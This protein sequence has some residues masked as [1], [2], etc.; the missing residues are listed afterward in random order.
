MISD[1]I[2]T[3]YEVLHSMKISKAKN[4]G[5]MAIKLDMSKA[6]DR[7][8]WNFIRA[9][10]EKLGFNAT[11]VSWI[12]QCITSASYAVLINGEAK[13]FIRP[14]R[15]IR[16]GDPLSPYLFI[17]CAEVLSCLL[18]KAEERDEFHG[19]K[20][21]RGAPSVNHLFFADDSLI[22]CGANVR[23][24]QNILHVIEIYENASGQRINRDK[25]NLFFN[26]NIGETIQATIKGFWGAPVTLSQEKYLGLH[27]IVGR[28]KK[29]AFVNLK[30]RVLKRIQG[31]R[32]KILSTGGKEIL[33]KAVAQ[34]IPSYTMSC[35]QLPKGLCNDLGAL[36]SKFW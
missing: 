14:T 8:E 6:Y 25:T 3:A 12:M 32:D 23:E 29:R 30:D 34:A 24:C 10:M 17:L 13:G 9:V 2:L 5:S 28:N 1:N 15:G 21:Y 36:C 18:F 33:I 20:I 35:F 16:Q 26:S 31:W 4:N 11:W 27:I 22:F 19:I 7:L